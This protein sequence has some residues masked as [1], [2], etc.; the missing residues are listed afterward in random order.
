MSAV[1][2]IAAL[3]ATGLATV[4]PLRHLIQTAPIWIPIVLGARKR[5]LVKWPALA[6]FLFWVAMQIIVWL[7]VLGWAGP[8][9]VRFTP[10]EIAL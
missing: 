4:T 2:L 6:I 10:T 7:Y 9:N 3:W 8:G 1:A 5:P